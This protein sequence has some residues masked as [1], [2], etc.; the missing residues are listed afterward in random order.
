MF[1]GRDDNVTLSQR[2]R[3]RDYYCNRERE[4]DITTK[5]Y[6]LYYL[7]REITTEKEKNN[8]YVQL[9]DVVES[10]ELMW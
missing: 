9:S 5:R 4:R 2:E 3:E 8:N 10:D 7:E 6:V 1:V